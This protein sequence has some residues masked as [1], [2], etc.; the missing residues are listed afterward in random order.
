MG[1][2]RTSLRRSDLPSDLSELRHLI[3]SKIPTGFNSH[4]HP[5]KFP[6]HGLNS[7]GSHQEMV[8]ADMKKLRI[9][10]VDTSKAACQVGTLGGGNHFIEICTDQEGFVWLTLHSGSRNVGLR[11]ADH[12]IKLVRDLPHNSSLPDRDLSAFLE[13][14]DEHR[15][16]MEA[17]TWAQEYASLNRIAMMTL[18]QE[19]I[20]STCKGSIFSLG[21]WCRHNFVQSEIHFGER[22]Y[23]TRKGAISARKDEMGMIPGSMGSK[24][25]I[26]KGLGCEESFTSAA[27]GAGRRMSRSAAKKLYSVTDLEQQTEGIECR[28]DRGVVDE[29]PSAYKD[30]DQV[31]ANQSDLVEIENVLKQLVCVKG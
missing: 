4:E 7:L 21:I 2:I 26:V 11:I 30:I 20:S 14:T 1:A 18:L 3:E 16:Y 17:V 19:V 23:V 12:F 9:P 13:G 25:Y 15:D 27:H 6:V 22:V 31:M 28:K 10:D 24:S 8:L 5:L 29:L